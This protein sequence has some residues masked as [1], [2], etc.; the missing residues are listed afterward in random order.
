MLVVVVAGDAEPAL[1][2]HPVMLRTEAHEIPRIRGAA[3]Q[4][5]D[6]VVDLDEPVGVAA[7]HGRPR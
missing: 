5:V 6:H 1:V 2:V 3:V 4:P 7:R